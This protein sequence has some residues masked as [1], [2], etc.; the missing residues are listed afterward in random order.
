MRFLVVALDGICG[1]A[2][3]AALPGKSNSFL[4]TAGRDQTAR[5]WDLK[6]DKDFVLRGHKGEV[7]DAMFN[8][9]PGPET[10]RWHIATADKEPCR[11]WLEQ[12]LKT[13][14]EDSPALPA[15]VPRDGLT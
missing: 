12:A 15:A 11:R 13:S 4:T 10:F 5:V 1:N 9:D 3:G 14:P 8:P 6:S 7:N 2:A